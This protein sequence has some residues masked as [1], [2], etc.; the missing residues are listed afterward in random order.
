MAATPILLGVIGRP[1]G[2]RGHVHV[3]SYTTQPEELADYASLT[4]GRGRCF[5]L[6]WVAAGIAEITD[7]TEGAKPITNRETAERL[8]NVQLFVDRAELP[9]PDEDEFYL[10]DL[11]GQ[12]AATSDGASLGRVTAVHDY[13]A[14]PSIEIA[15]A[16]GP[17]ILVPF[18]RACVPTIDLAAG[19][20]IVALPDELLVEDADMEDAE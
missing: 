19:R 1:H 13:G 17:P 20:L 10:A 6:R 8:T 5:R 2:V 4:D 18:T 7:L 11:I 3:H 9:P 16:A 12:H 14:G 15:G